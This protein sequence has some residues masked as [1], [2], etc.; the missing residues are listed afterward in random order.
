[1]KYLT[2]AT[3]KRSKCMAGVEGTYD[4]KQVS[5]LCAQFLGPLYWEFVTRSS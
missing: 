5:F 4:A 3:D 1:M 2:I